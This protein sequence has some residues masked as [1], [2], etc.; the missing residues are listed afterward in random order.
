[1]PADLQPYEQYKA[2]LSAINGLLVYMDRIVIP[3]NLRTD[4]LN[5]LHESHQGTTK[6]LDNAHTCMWWPS[7]TREVKEMVNSCM[8]CQETR[9]AQR[10][11]PLKP[12]EIPSRPWEKVSTD[13]CEHE[14]K[15]YLV[16]IDQYSRWIK[17]K[18]LPSATSGAVIS[19]F[20]DI[21]ATHGIM[22]TL[23]SDKGPQF[24]SQEFT[25][26]AAKYGFCQISSSPHNL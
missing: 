7:I 24:V 13:L 20:K 25:E 9:P 5:R 4:M 17:V 26:F 18:A 16:V 3:S 21:I 6:C 19:R 23:M 14:G 2:E 11:A 10:Q 1:M 22:D 8:E 12:T 15:T